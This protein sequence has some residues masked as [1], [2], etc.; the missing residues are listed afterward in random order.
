MAVFPAIKPTRRSFSFGDYPVK[1]YRALSGK[2]VRRSFGSR[3]YGHLL[4]LS[5]EGVAD[6]IVNQLFDHY[7]GQQGV[8][9]GFTLPDEV[10]SG[11]S[12]ELRSRLKAPSSIEWLYAE[13]P[14]VESVY[15]ERSNVTIKLIG[16][17][18]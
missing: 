12:V 3:P 11:I 13:T 15:N 8:T 9:I 16:E 10:F 1:A 14:N 6:G 4:E 5:F 18:V 2:V 17:L 7:H